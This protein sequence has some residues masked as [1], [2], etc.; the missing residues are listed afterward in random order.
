MELTSWHVPPV[1]LMKLTF[2]TAKLTGAPLAVR[3]SEALG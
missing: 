2:L 1:G 3:P